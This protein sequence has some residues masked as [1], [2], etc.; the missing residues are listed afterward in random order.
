M[1]PAP[2]SGP[3]RSKT[4]RIERLRVSKVLYSVT[5]SLDGYIAGP[6]GD[7]SWLRPYLQPNPPIEELQQ[8]IGALLVGGRTHRG[9]DP[10]RGTSQEGAFEGTWDGPVFVVTRRPSTDEGSLHFVDT[11][12]AGLKAAKLAA[13]GRYVNVLGAELAR[14]CLDLGEVDEILTIIAPVLLGGGTPLFA[15]PEGRQV[16]LER[17]DV[18]V[19]PHVTNVWHRVVRDAGAPLTRQGAV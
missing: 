5:M 17:L 3:L 15:H 6:D 1:S 9:D 13:A 4:L 19:L 10:H 14:E 12:Q 18:Q 16:R 8:E 7:M 2:A 11:P